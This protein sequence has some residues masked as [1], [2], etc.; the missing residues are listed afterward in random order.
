MAIKDIDEFEEVFICYID[1]VIG[2]EER[3]EELQNG[4][5]FRCLCNCCT[6]DLEL[7]ARHQFKPFKSFVDLSSVKVLLKILESSN[8]ASIELTEIFFEN[9]SS[10][11]AKLELT[12]NE[13]PNTTGFNPYISHTQT[14][15]LYLF[16]LH[17]FSK[18]FS[19]TENGERA[20]KSV[21][22]T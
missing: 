7:E 4:W 13:N 6:E 18:L 19:P 8:T 3:K 1:L 17:N 21:I 10:L 16:L 12:M 15:V 2:V 20:E 5:D 9:Y 11:E 14:Q 22:D